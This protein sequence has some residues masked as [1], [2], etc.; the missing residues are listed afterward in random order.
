MATKLAVFIAGVA[1]LVAAV[2][3]PAHHTF[4]ALYDDS[5]PVNL[6]GTVT[7]LDWR[8]PHVWLYI[9]VEGPDGRVANWGLELSGV[10]ILTRAGWKRDSVKAGDV[11]IVE[12]VRARDGGNTANGKSIVL[13]S[14]GQTLFRGNAPR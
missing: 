3:A 14:T 10:N 5:K 7:K 11:V 6:K 1:L 4:A 12:G 2:P 13:A 8:N 9:D